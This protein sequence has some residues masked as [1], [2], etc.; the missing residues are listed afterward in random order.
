MDGK[1]QLAVVWRFTATQLLPGT[2]VRLTRIRNQPQ[3]KQTDELLAVA[4]AWL[5]SILLQNL[6]GNEKCHLPYVQFGTV[7]VRRS[8][9]KY[10][11]ILGL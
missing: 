2:R 7:F 9:H 8:G 5:I 6:I 4:N 1:H 3:E 10:V 11:L